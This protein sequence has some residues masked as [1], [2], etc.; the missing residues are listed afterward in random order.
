[1]IIV[2]FVFASD[3]VEADMPFWCSFETESFIAVVVPFHFVAIE[4]LGFNQESH[5]LT[6][7]GL[8]CICG[9]EVHRPDNE[10]LRIGGEDA[11]YE[12]K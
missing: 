8:R 7:R 4:V 3:M 10:L 12:Y 2:C 1:M 5:D 11:A 6:V 9:L